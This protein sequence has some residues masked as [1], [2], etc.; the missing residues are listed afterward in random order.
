MRAGTISEEQLTRI[1]AVDKVR[2]EQRKR[3]VEEEVDAYR[4]LFL[5]GDGGGEGERSILEKAARRAD[6][7]QYVLVLLGDLLDGM[8]FVFF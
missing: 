3:I 7:V 1:R 5:G 8:F 4:A 6:V 2:K